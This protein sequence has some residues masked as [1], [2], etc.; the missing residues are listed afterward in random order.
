MSNN[1]AQLFSE[2]AQY[3]KALQWSS[4]AINIPITN[5]MD[6]HMETGKMDQLQTIYKNYI[7]DNPKDYDTMN[8][9]AKLL[10]LKGDIE[11]AGEVAMTIPPSK[12]DSDF[13]IGFNNEVK[14]DTDQEQTLYI[15][16]FKILMDM[17]SLENLP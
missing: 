14:E 12:L 13:K 16:K 3:E 17:P 11:A 1:I 4:C 7:K 15:S 6:W 10:L 5:L 9:M 2:Y 8:Y